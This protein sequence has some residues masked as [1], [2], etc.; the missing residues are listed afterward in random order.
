MEERDRSK[1]QGRR[2]DRRHLI[3]YLKVEN[4]E[5][6]ELIGRIVDITSKGILLI[7]RDKISPNTEYS[8]RIE[9]GDELFDYLHGHLEMHIRCRWSKEDINPDYFVNGFEFI[10]QSTEQEF[11]IRNLIE[12]IGFVE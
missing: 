10:N 9:L 4:K 7:S 5:T 2:E 3:Y 12:V 11:I 1:S 6:N 8:V